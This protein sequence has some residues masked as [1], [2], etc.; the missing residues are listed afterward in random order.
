MPVKGFCNIQ[1][2]KTIYD[3]LNWILHRK[4]NELNDT[5][6]KSKDRK[7]SNAAKF[8]LQTQEKL[9]YGPGIAD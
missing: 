7:D 8:V 6:K 5:R 1:N 3:L 2:V 9:T 4:L